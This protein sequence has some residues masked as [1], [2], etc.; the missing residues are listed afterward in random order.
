MLALRPCGR[1]P[2]KGALPPGKAGEPS[3][4]STLA[5]ALLTRLPTHGLGGFALDEGTRASFFPIAVFPLEAEFL[6]I[7]HQAVDPESG[8][9]TVN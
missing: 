5:S 4:G 6:G 7:D 3:G 1:S 9:M 8:G 2:C